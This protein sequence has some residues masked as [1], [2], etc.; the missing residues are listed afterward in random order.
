MDKLNFTKILKNCTSEGS[1]NR[2]KRQ[3]SEW[4]DT[5]KSHIS[6]EDPENF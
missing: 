6:P 1:I 3:P 4:E 2:V 5:F